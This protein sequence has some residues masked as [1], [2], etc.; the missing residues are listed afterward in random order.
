MPAYDP[1]LILWLPLHL[2]DCVSGDSFM[3]R[4]AYGHL[5]TVSGASWT[6]YGYSF[7]GVSDYLRIAGLDAIAPAQPYTI[8]LG[9]KP[10]V[11]TGVH[12][13]I[14]AGNNVIAW[15]IRNDVP[16]YMRLAAGA[17]LDYT[18]W[19]P[20]L[21]DRYHVA[22][23]LNGADSA[24]YENGELKASGDAG[25]GALQANTDIAMTGPPFN[26]APYGGLIDHIRIYSRILTPAEIQRAYID[27]KRRYQ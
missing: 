6:P 15:D 7:D 3:S 4:D 8:L 26:Q 10:T 12:R 17:N 11:F 14:V 23:I 13:L 20:T 22:A 1:S 19:T 25:A 9:V 24:I 18:S 27:T 2:R 5:C 16:D 21:E